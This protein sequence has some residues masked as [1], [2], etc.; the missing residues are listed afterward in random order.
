MNKYQKEYQ[1]QRLYKKPEYGIT[2]PTENDQ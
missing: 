2:T 1:R